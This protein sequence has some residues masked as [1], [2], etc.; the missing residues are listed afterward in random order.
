MSTAVNH[1]I[2]RLH[3]NIIYWFRLKKNSY[4]LCD[5]FLLYLL[6]INYLRIN[7]IPYNKVLTINTISYYYEFTKKN[8][9]PI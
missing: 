7:Y 8:G 2:K 1:Y 4:N 6:K 5:V 9:V 3:R